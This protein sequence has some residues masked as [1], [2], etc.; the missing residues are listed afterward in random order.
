M[1]LLGGLE[2]VAAGYLM[3]KH[4]KNKKERARLAEEEAE[5]EEEEARLEEEYRRTHPRPHSSG[6]KHRRR[7][8]NERRDTY[9]PPRREHSAPPASP[10]SPP[11]GWPA[12]WAQSQQPEANQGRPA[13]L[14][15]NMN[16]YTHA[17]HGPYVGGSR[18][19]RARSQQD[20]P[21]GEKS[22][23]FQDQNT[24]PVGNRPNTPGHVRFAVGDDNESEFG[25]RRDPPPAYTA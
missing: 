19:G 1:V 13:N 21:R 10:V 16:N 6:H 24:V 18:S 9:V 3:H 4:Q 12:H 23:S 17:L 15:P 8:S 22:Q 14:S 25:E 20:I 2:I 11:T 5:L 7:H